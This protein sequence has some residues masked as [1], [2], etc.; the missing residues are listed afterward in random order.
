MAQASSSSNDAPMVAGAG[1]RDLDA[2][3]RQLSH[4][5]QMDSLLEG[6]KRM[7][8]ARACGTTATPEEL[9]TREMLVEVFQ[10]ASLDT[11]SVLAGLG[12]EQSQLTE[13]RAGLQG[14]RDKTVARL[15]TA[16]LLTGA[17][18]GTAVS[19]TQFTTLGSRTQNTGDAL[20]VGGGAVSTVLSLL[21][22]RK[23]GG[24]SGT[25]RGTQT[26]LAP[27][28]GDSTGSLREYPQ[29][30]MDYLNAVPDDGRNGAQ[31]RVE[32]LRAGWVKAGRLTASGGQSVAALTTSNDPAVKVSIDDLSSRIAMLG[33][34]RGRVSLMKR[35]LAV[36]RRA[37]LGPLQC[38]R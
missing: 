35:D 2:D 15:N 19:A 11:E 38:G 8:A 22:A 30:V 28:L 20:G 37:S 32:Q 10:A 29:V 25:V 5:L 23:Q 13:T 31:T 1:M 6:V 33:D 16:A 26:M 18:L 17:A 12:D 27:L 34:V 21:A 7:R 14:R 36:L 4:L 9:S 3:A 24:P